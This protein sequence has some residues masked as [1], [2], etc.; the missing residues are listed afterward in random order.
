[1]GVQVNERK[2]ARINSRGYEQINGINYDESSILTQVINN[3]SVEV[4]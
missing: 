1:M 3:A 2:I 4:S